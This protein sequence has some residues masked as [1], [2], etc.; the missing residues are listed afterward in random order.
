MSTDGGVSWT[1]CGTDSPTY[2]TSPTK[3]ENNGYQYM[4]VVTG[5][6]ELDKEEQPPKE[7]IP[8]EGAVL[9][10]RSRSR[11]TDDGLPD[12]APATESPIFTLEVIRKDAI[13]QTGD[14]SRPA[15][16]L[17]LLGACCAGLWCVSRRRG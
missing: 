11:S 13:P 5:L 3:L 15:A 10:L 7:E 14:S 16:W 8:P 9:S 2:T 1:E 4:C 12:N 17:A 6:N